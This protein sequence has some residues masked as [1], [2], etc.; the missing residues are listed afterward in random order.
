MTRHGTQPVGVLCPEET[1]LQLPCAGGNLAIGD[2]LICR[3]NASGFV[4]DYLMGENPAAVK[5]GLREGLREVFT[6]HLALEFYHLLFAHGKP[7]IKGAKAF[8]GNKGLY[9]LL[10]VLFQLLNVFARE[11]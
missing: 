1:A 6:H 3:S 10:I 9:G 2:A 7:W 8:R 11:G 5:K 4:P